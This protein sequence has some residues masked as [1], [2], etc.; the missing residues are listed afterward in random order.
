MTCKFTENCSIFFY[1]KPIKT[2]VFFN[3]KKEINQIT[4]PMMKR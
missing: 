2:F 1:G 4:V 3:A